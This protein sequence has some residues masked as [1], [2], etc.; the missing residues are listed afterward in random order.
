[1]NNTNLTSSIDSQSIFANIPESYTF[2]PKL[3]IAINTRD[4]QK[5]IKRTH[6]TV[7]LCQTAKAEK[8]MRVNDREDTPCELKVVGASQKTN[9]KN[10]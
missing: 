7:L 6:D 3:C 2:F 10:R 1:M 8:K 5:Q 4:A 9:K